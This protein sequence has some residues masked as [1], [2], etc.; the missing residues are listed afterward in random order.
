MRHNLIRKSSQAVFLALFIYIFWPAS[1]PLKGILSAE[2]FLKTDPLI[3]FLTSIS[4]RIILP[5][6][7]LSFIMLLLT[8]VF[9]RFFCGW[10]CPLGTTIDLI[11]CLDRRKPVKSNP[12]SNKSRRIKFFI[13]AIIAFSALLGIQLV[14]F[15][16]PVAIM[17]RLV[18]LNLLAGKGIQYLCYSA[19]V[20]I[21]FA[22]IC[23]SAFF[24][25]RFWCRAFCPLGA[26]YVLAARF[27]RFVRPDFKK[28]AAI[29]GNNDGGIS[30]R[31]FIFLLFSS[32]FLVGFRNKRRVS[33]TARRVIRPPAAMEESVFVDRCIRCGSCTRAC[34]T[35]GLQP[36]MFESGLEGIWTPHLVPEIGY[37]DYNCAL[38][39]G[40]C[41]TGAIRRLPLK[42]KQNTRL[43][44]ADVDRSV[45]LAWSKNQQCLI[46]ER[47]C[48]V[49]EKAIKIQRDTISGIAVGKPVVDRALCIGCGVCQNKCPAR[50]VRAIRVSPC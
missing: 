21:F 2:I 30:R 3:V 35:N 5:G 25:G 1:S 36:A 33:A 7:A 38:C 8:L 13:L 40:V 4:E 17:A 10:I 49:Q 37:C 34:I 39:G 9:G 31:D 46:C 11:G 15:F 29:G 16:D 28:G 14:W 22:A 18:S 32:A 24:A 26:L 48:P 45:C 44:L 47:H 50:P 43:G 19:V 27:S 6:V 20:I 12:A 41:P 23:V 42:E